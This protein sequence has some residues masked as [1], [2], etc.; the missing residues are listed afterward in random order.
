MDYLDQL[1]AESIYILREVA[2]QF[3]NPALLFSGGK[4]SITLVHL[5]LKAFRPGK[6]PFPLVHIDTGH[7]FPETI[8]YRDWLVEQIGEKLIVGHVQDSIDAGKVVEQKG[9]NA[10]RNALQTVTLLDT[11][12]ENGFD[13]CIGGA[14]RDEEKARAKERVF[15]VRDEFGQW[16]P[17]RQRPELWNIF[18]G[19]INKGENVRV[20]PI[21]NWTELDV[22]NYIKRENIKLPSIYFSHEREVITRNGQLMAAASFLNIDEE[23]VVE[24]K[25]VRFRTVGDMTCTAAVDSQAT[26]LDDIIAE[27]KASTVSERGARMDDKVSEA[28]MEDRKKQ[29][30]F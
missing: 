13:A 18:N 14:R 9:K 29:G 5:A 11:I 8:A 12:A 26:A 15:S 10:S 2:G 28:A 17:K 21:S 23:D 22:W 16:D 27:I 6:F 25:S 30:Y 4:D 1:E 7:N 24:T 3:E 20:F 19:K